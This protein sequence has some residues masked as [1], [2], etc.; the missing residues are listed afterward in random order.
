M[1]TKPT[2]KV[3]GSSGH[4]IRRMQCGSWPTPRKSLCFTGS[5]PLILQGQD[6][7]SKQHRPSSYGLGTWQILPVSRNAS[8]IMGGTG[9][10]FC[11]QLHAFVK[12][13]PHCASKQL[14]SRAG[15]SKHT[16]ASDSF[17]CRML[18]KLGCHPCCSS[19]KLELRE[20]I[21]LFSQLA[22]SPD[23]GPQEKT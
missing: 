3:E 17:R 10:V 4:A 15:Q 9:F 23:P 16:V 22:R 13:I 14:L 6:S 19:A 5:H 20:S 12:V 2:C 1:L 21:Y 7:L 18:S 11:L 8:R